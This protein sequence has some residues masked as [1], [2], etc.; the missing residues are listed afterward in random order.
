MLR[1]IFCD[2]KPQNVAPAPPAVSGE[3]A[4]RSEHD[5]TAARRAT[6]PSAALRSS[7]RAPA[8]EGSTDERSESVGGAARRHV[9]LDAG[10]FRPDR[11]AHVDDHPAIEP[12]NLA[13][14][15]T[16]EAPTDP[17]QESEKIETRR[18]QLADE[19]DDR[20]DIHDGRRVHH[21]PLQE[22]HEADF[23]VLL[24]PLLLALSP[25]RQ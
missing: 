18:P 9:H 22:G 17:P 2:I 23:S 16:V 6:A 8:S 12:G 21:N 1:P 7:S 15:P 5:W 19:F 20:R 13:G 11:L 10:S 24:S 14:S 25:A 4:Q 3:S